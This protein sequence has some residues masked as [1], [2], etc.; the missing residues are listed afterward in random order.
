MIKNK[1][2]KKNWFKGK[3]NISYK[4]SI[5]FKY[6]ISTR[7]DTTFSSLLANYR[8]KGFCCE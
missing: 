7:N 1:I 5:N 6:K 8:V 4:L 2:V 3:I